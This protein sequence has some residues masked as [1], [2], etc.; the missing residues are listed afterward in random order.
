MPNVATETDNT[1]NGQPDLIGDI[2]DNAPPPNETVVERIDLFGGSEDSKPADTVAP[3][4]DVPTPQM[5]GGVQFDP[6]I[7]ETNEDGTPRLTASGKPRRKRGRG[8]NKSAA[9][10]AAV[11]PVDYV[12]TGRMITGMFFGLSV[13]ALGKAWEPNPT[14]AAQIEQQMIRV[15]ESNQWGDLPPT[16]GLTLAVA[17]YALPRL[18][19]PE[20]KERMQAWAV[21]LG[22][23]KPAPQIRT[24]RSVPN[25]DTIPNGGTGA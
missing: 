19:L 1:P 25:P 10:V 6:A 7:H 14:E 8:G 20:T 16:I 12:A 13:N 17:V 15:C 22:L 21:H 5:Y 11:A 23:R 24:I 4:V 3:S 9:S 2:V 18:P